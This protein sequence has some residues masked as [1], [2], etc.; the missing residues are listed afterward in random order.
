V[1]KSPQTIIILMIFNLVLS[2][3][4]LTFMLQS[5][6]ADE[7]NPG[8]YSPTSK[9]F[10][11]PF[12]DWTA[13]WWQWYLKIPNS[14][15]P[16]A[17]TTGEKCAVSQDG[18]VWFLLGSAGKVERNCTIPSDKAIMFPILDTSCSYSE[19]PNL[20]SE[21]ELRQC[22]I[23]GNKDA[24]VKASVDNQE[25][26]N[27]DRYR[28]TTGLFNVTYSDDPVS[29]TNSN[30]SQAVSD[31]WFIFLEPLKAG[32]HE[33]KFVAS[34]LSGENAAEPSALID[35]TY[36]LVVAANSTKSLASQ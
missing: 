20:K 17:D 11:I 15:H 1:K 19:S 21:Q 27:I 28:V 6:T 8:L 23:D 25:V 5:V 35:V 22:A 16:F 32:K 30:V 31:G 3:L 9:L 24:I 29:P 26:K 18:P 14:Q 33:I 34:Q 2:L 7:V 36:H 12:V 4:T 13:K 10:G